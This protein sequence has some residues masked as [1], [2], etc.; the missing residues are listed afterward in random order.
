MTLLIASLLTQ[1]N[2][3][4]IPDSVFA[5]TQPGG[6]RLKLST[7]DDPVLKLI[8]FS[9]THNNTQTRHRTTNPHRSQRSATYR[10]R[11]RLAPMR[12]TASKYIP[13]IHRPH[14]S[15]VRRFIQLCDLPVCACVCVCASFTFY[16]QKV[17]RRGK[18]HRIPGLFQTCSLSCPICG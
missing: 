14:R 12:N 8:R 18:K 5:G 11:T 1:A 6:L 17:L 7:E 10:A 3:V 2:S 13:G 15:C 4:D 16:T 9:H